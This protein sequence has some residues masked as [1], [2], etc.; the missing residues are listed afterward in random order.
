MA[1]TTLSN[2]PMEK[3]LLLAV[4]LSF[5]VLGVYT[6]LISNTKT[7]E[8]TR[9]TSN[10]TSIATIENKQALPVS[11]KSNKA[12]NLNDNILSDKDLVQIENNGLVFKFSIRG[13]YLYQIIDKENNYTLGITNIGLVREWAGYHFVAHKIT[14]GLIFL[15][16][17]ADGLEIKKTFRIKEANI[18]ELAI[19]INGATDSS[20]YSYN[21]SAGS[22][23][24]DSEKDQIAARY[25][26][27]CVIVNG[28]TNRK[29]IFN[30]KDPINYDGHVLWAGLRDR[31][32]CS[33]LYPQ[34]TVNKGV[35]A[36]IDK[37]QYL[38]LSSPARN[39]LAPRG[40]TEDIYGIYI[41]LQDESALRKFG[42]SSERII[43]YGT[44]DTISKLLLFF[45]KQAYKITK[46]WGLAI[47]LIT[48]FVYILLFPLSMKS[49]VSMKK[50]QAIQPKIEELRSKLKDNPQKLNMEIMQLY[51]QEKVNPFGG[52]LPMLLQIPV[53]FALYQLLMRFISL[54]GASFLWIKDLS[55]P[56]RLMIFKNS[57]P[58]LGNELNILPLLMAV[59]MFVQQKITSTQASTSPE[60][61]QQQKIMLV[62][63][64]VLFGFLFY[65]LASGLVLYWF[66]NNLLMIAFQWKIS[67]TK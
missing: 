63:M 47:I 32:F 50:M 67:R 22:F 10:Q 58:V 9:V 45:L 35:V 65:K 29:A 43:S 61:A 3:R 34:N 64:P 13:G 6:A 57:L 48:I 17:D 2:N 19:E 38:L 54:K 24:A 62:M 66:V 12:Q 5:L 14:R 60:M 41:G 18:L 20:V 16:K 15:Y 53:F 36:I 46:N 4:A 7:I 26:E 33:I 21:I 25:H 31:Y 8:N 49:M 11:E 44:F 56:D 37:A 28:I 30:L 42:V 55:E 52:C 59:G 40:K 51:K 23:S 39:N 1:A 27:V